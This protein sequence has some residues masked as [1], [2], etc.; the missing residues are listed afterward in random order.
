MSTT[1]LNKEQQER[2]AGVFGNK[3]QYTEH[4][5]T[6][7]ALRRAVQEKLDIPYNSR[8]DKESPLFKLFSFTNELIGA[9][10][11]GSVYI[12]NGEVKVCET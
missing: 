3:E 6:L 12:V 10:G 11:D 4:L 8:V 1:Y 9:V 5:K 2:L 7:W